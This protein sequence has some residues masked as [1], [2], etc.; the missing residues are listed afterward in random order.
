MGHFMTL[1]DDQMHLDCYNAGQGSVSPQ[2][3]K[4]FQ[5][6]VSQKARNF[7]GVFRVT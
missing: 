6:P 1:I 4:L 7:S 3:R 5:G 2:S